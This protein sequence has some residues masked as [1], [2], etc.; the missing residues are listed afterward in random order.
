MQLQHHTRQLRI[1]MQPAMN[2]LVLIY[3]SY[4][5]ND[6]LCFFT[7]FNFSF[8]HSYLWQKTSARPNS[9]TSLILYLPV[10]FLLC[11]YRG[12]AWQ[13]CQ[14][15]VCVCIIP[16][17]KD[18]IA[19]VVMQLIIIT[20][21][22]D[23]FNMKFCSYAPSILPMKPTNICIRVTSENINQ[24]S[25]STSYT[26]VRHIRAFILIRRIRSCE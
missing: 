18:Y 8:Y 20:T 7:K 10:Q 16:V 4:N 11:L 23:L 3:N 25:I 19:A 2:V 13:L 1:I 26:K 6:N 14:C 22:R 12:S 15:C 5:H 17:R 21:N 24:Y 9:P